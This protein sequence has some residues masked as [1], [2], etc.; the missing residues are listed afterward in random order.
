MA[1][2]RMIILLLAQHRTKTQPDID[3]DRCLRAR[4][5]MHRPS[6]S[7]AVVEDCRFDGDGDGGGEC[8]CVVVRTAE[9]DGRRPEARIVCVDVQINQIFYSFK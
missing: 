8:A 6:A 1:A 9:A 5:A 3:V 2:G 4:S 7:E